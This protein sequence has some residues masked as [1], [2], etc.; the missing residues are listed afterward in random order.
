VLAGADAKGGAPISIATRIQ[1]RE[2]TADDLAKIRPL[3]DALY[4][5]QREHGLL[6]ELAPEAFT[7]W[8]GGMAVVLGRFAC[9][10][11]AEEE[12]EPVGFIAG[13]IRTPPPPFGPEPVG[14]ISEVYVADA[15]RGMG[16]G[17]DLLAAAEAWFARE[18][19][20]RLELQVLAGNAAAV[21][22]YERLGWKQ[23]LIQ[24]VRTVRP[25]PVQSS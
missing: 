7:Q 1:L 24:M 21:A 18:G 8:A 22:A 6:T 10:Y 19:I 25:V 4:V 15:C 9:L 23:E 13:R 12:T 17:R 16:V 2:G 14:F 5:H 11:M 20:E 3:W